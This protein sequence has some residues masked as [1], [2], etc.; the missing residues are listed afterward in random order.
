MQ[1]NISPEEKLLRLIRNPKKAP[2]TGLAQGHAGEVFRRAPFS[3]RLS[4]APQSLQKYALAFLAAAS[5]YLAA[6]L[7]RP[8]FGFR[9]ITL[10]DR[11]GLPAAQ[12]ASVAGEEA[13]PFD[14]YAAPLKERNV[15]ID[16]SAIAPAGEDGVVQVAAAD[17]IKD[18]TLVGIIMGP[19]PQAV[20]EDKAAQRT[21]YVSKGQSIRQM[22]IEDIQEGKIILKLK[23]EKFELTI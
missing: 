16:Y 1:D 17:M 10:E 8:F 6:S 15:F 2:L 20:I 22:Q 5:L 4:L 23:G 3:F 7:A 9:K 11:P 19:S 18:I 21:F 13:K 14:F 12:N